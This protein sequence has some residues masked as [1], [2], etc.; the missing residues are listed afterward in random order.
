M[1]T[2]GEI[3]SNLF[4]KLADMGD[5]ELFQTLKSEA[6]DH[7]D[8]WRLS[9]AW[10]SLSSRLPSRHANA[11]ID[12]G[13]TNVGPLPS[14]KLSTAAIRK[15]CAWT[16]GAKIREAPILG[17]GGSV[18]KIPGARGHSR[19]HPLPALSA[20]SARLARPGIIA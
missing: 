6:A 3:L 16:L 19:G 14:H 4:P 13:L 12:A 1:F 9:V 15:K 2:V 10:K 11:V 5:F 8:D 17:G 20:L 18:I 7:L